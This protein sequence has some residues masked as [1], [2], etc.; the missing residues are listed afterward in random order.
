MNDIE[1]MKTVVQGLIQPKN[2][3]GYR[4]WVQKV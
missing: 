1:K 4:F 3:S 2:D